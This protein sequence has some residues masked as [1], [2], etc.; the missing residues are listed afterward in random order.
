M[1]IPWSFYFEGSDIFMKRIIKYAFRYKLLVIVPT[2][3]MLLGVILD[4]F[5]PYF[6]KVM[7]DSVITKG[8]LGLLPG[9]LLAI[10]SITIGRSVLGYIKEY[11][12]DYL[13]TEVAQQ[14]KEDLYNH[15]QSLPYSYFDE[16]NTGE[17]MSRIGEDVLTF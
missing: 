11:V 4:L 1:G 7:I 9:I 8:K 16:M 17:L 12:S 14:M 10:A 2:I 13:S 6:S 5:N 3:A 15:I